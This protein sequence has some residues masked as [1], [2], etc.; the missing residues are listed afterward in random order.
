[1]YDF[2]K[3]GQ[4]ESEMI[5]LQHLDPQ[6]RIQQT[7]DHDLTLGGT[8][9]ILHNVENPLRTIKITARCGQSTVYQMLAL[10]A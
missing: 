6:F 9:T 4:S 2:I 7:T 10:R 3:K 5:I 8:S 1:M